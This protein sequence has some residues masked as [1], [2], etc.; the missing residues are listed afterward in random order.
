MR[1]ARH[2]RAQT[3]PEVA[4]SRRAFDCDANP[5]RLTYKTHAR[6]LSARRRR[7]W[8]PASREPRNKSGAL[9]AKTCERRDE[10]NESSFWRP[11]SLANR[12]RAARA[13]QARADRQSSKCSQ[14][15][16]I[17][18]NRALLRGECITQS[19]SILRLAGRHFCASW[20]A[21]QASGQRAASE[22]PSEPPPSRHRTPASLC[23]APIGPVANSRRARCICHY[24][25]RSSGAACRRG[26]RKR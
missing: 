23:G 18:S 19:P 10:P 17:K 8:A 25:R 12:R 15:N 4:T 2:F 11:G 13:R 3:A 24:S 1:R 26:R 20:P 9:M 14:S 21:R 22:P 16:Q 5:F 7:K 6:A